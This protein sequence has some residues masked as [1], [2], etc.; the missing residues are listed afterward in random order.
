M[1]ESVNF[2]QAQSF[3]NYIRI[4]QE[5]L[6][7]LLYSGF[8][9]GDLITAHEGV[10]GEKVLTEMILGTLVH[11]WR[12]T[13]DPTAGA[14][15]FNPRVLTVKP[16]KVDLQVYP[17]EYEDSYLGMLR[18]KGFKVDD[19]P[20]QLYVLSQILAKIAEEKEIAIWQGI[21]TGSA[22]TDPLTSLINGFLKQIADGITATDITVV[23]TG[24]LTEAD[25]IDQVEAVHSGLSPAQQVA[26][27]YGFVSLATYKL[28][29]RAYRDQVSKYTGVIQSNGREM[30]KL[31]FAPA[32]LVPT[33]G[34]G[35]SSRIIFT[36][37]MNFHH[38]YDGASDGQTIT[39]EKNH[40]ALDLMIDFKFG[41][42]IGIMKNAILRVNDQA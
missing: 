34:M 12:K 25:I 9:T 11:R 38:G 41:A 24:A 36:D 8:S 1:S 33:V 42:G 14:I 18:Q 27:T 30:V 20:F 35:T 16:A 2:T 4:F 23:S 15:D 5:K 21:M 39:I 3:Q 7:T 13:F 32:W 40:R 26:T 19:F 6:L 28:Y 29:L 31:D 22:V 37:P 17:Q 10:K